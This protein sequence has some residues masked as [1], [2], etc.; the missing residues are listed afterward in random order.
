MFQVLVAERSQWDAAALDA[1]FREIELAA[2]ALEARRAANLIAGEARQV[3]D[4]DGHRSTRAYV[5]ATAHASAGDAG[6]MVRRARFVRDHPLVGEALASGRLGVA[7]VD[8]LARAA[9]HRR[10]G[11]L[12]DDAVV[13]MF[14]E[15]AEHFSYAD[16]DML[17]G[18][19]VTL[20]DQDG[21]WRDHLD[22]LEA[23]TAR[24][25]VVGGEAD[26]SATGGD[27]LTAE[28]LRLIMDR[29]VEAE[30]E[31]DAAERRDRY[32]DQADAYPLARSDA[33]RRFDAVVAIFDTANAHADAPGKPVDATVD[34]LIDERTLH[35]AL[36][37]EGVLLPSGDVFDPVDLERDEYQELLTELLADP[38]LLFRRRCDT[39]S[40]QPVH[41]RLVAQA[42]L[43]GYVRRVVVDSDGVPISF[44]R[45]QRC[46]TGPAKVVARLQNAVCEHPGCGLPAHLCD[47]DHIEPFSGGGATDQ[48]NAAVLC[49]THN[50]MKHRRRWR[51]RRGAN[52]KLY[53]YRADGT[54]MLAVGE[55]PPDPT[56]EHQAAATRARMQS[57]LPLRPTA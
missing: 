12:F 50:R 51:T 39:A 31:R 10:V 7:Q 2:R 8:L 25:G 11:A 15:H 45:S 48:A 53:T 20:A 17:V 3:A 43:T 9:N 19:W 40:G 42:L 33:Q 41:P 52:R 32:G 16:L 27:A 24:V 55:R 34:V 21:A 18:R 47:T 38:Q 57:L 5:R 44:G 23:R 28:R 6:R 30:F 29:Y 14:V 13:A 49:S 56:D 22:S 54:L 37:S 46:F 1:E 26:I 35:S 4:L 36:A